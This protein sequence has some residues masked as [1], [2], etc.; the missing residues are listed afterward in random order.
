MPETTEP[1][2]VL[3]FNRD[4]LTTFMNRLSPDA[5]G[6]F[7]YG[8]LVAH[9]YPAFAEGVIEK[10]MEELNG[11]PVTEAVPYMRENLELSGF[12]FHMEGGDAEVATDG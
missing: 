8:V 2:E 3:E 1:R 12:T 5:Y 11:A 9:R 6:A 7:L 4:A 10:V